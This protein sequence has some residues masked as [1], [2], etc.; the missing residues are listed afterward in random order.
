ML[1]Q[2]RLLNDISNLIVNFTTIFFFFFWAKTLPLFITNIFKADQEY[3]VF[4]LIG[5][6]VFILL[7]H[8]VTGKWLQTCIFI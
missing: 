5:H 1:N 4:F 2:H 6:D 3:D 7:G 8:T